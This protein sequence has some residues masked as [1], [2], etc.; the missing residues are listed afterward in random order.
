MTF[1]PT[2]NRVT[3]HPHDQAPAPLTAEVVAEWPAHEDC[4]TECWF[5]PTLRALLSQIEEDGGRITTLSAQLAE[6]EKELARVTAERDELTAA[7]DSIETSEGF[8]ANGNLWRFWAGKAREIAAD[9][10]K[11][12]ASEANA[13]ARIA[14]LTEAADD[15]KGWLEGALQCKDWV[16]DTD[17]YEYAQ[18]S[19]ADYTV[20]LTTD[21]GAAS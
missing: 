11:L 5:A 19:I 1:D 8:T 12:L 3:T 2:Q 7:I 4:K 16:W 10:T 14:A 9:Q 13:T 21:K 15:M 6:R 18:Q 20:A 17:Q